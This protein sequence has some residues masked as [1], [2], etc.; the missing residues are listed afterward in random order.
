MAFIKLFC[1]VSII[2]VLKRHLRLIH[3]LEEFPY[4]IN[5]PW[6][7]IPAMAASMLSITLVIVLMQTFRA[8]GANPVTGLRSE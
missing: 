8:A 5:V 2:D 1:F 3:Y 6:W 7:V 4:H